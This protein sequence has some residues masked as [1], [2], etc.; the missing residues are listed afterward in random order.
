MRHAKARAPIDT[1][2]FM[3]LGIH[4]HE[5]KASKENNSPTAKAVPDITKATPKVV[6]VLLKVMIPLET[7][8]VNHF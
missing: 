7:Q 2:R 4:A 1:Q 5:Q 8:S 6:K 3:D